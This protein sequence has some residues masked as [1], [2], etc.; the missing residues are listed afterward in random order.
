MIFDLDGTLVDIDVDWE[1]YKSE[2]GDRDAMDCLDLLEKY[3]MKN[4]EKMELK[5]DIVNMAK[6]LSNKKLAIFSKTTRRVVDEAIKRMGIEF[7]VVVTINDVMKPKPD[8]EGIE[9]ILKQLGIPKEKTIYIG[10]RE[11]DK[12]AGERAGVKTV[13]VNEL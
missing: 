9:I 10:D 5:Q 12:I 1:S 2:R 3:E 4:I 6:N 8:P 13:L 7:D 11:V